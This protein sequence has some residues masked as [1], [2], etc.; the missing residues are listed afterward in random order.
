ML[1][2]GIARVGLNS[3]RG[4]ALDLNFLSGAF[5]GRI[6]FSRPSSATRINAAG[7]LEAVAAGTPR[8]DYDPVTLACKGLLVEEQ[9]TNYIRNSTMQGAAAGVLPTNWLATTSTN[10]ITRSVVGTGTED[11]IPYV[12]VRFAGTPTT[13]NQYVDVTF[14]GQN[15]TAASGQTWTLA[16]YLRLVGGSLA[17][18]TNPA[19]IGYAVPGFSDM[20]N[21]PISGLSGAP[22]RTQRISGSKTYSDATM[23]GISPRVG[24]TINAGA[25]VD[26]TVRIGLPQLEQG[27]FSTSPIPTTTA[28][29]TRA[30]DIATLALGSWFN[31]AEGTLVADVTERSGAALGAI[32]ELN[33]GSYINRISLVRPT[34][35]ALYAGLVVVG[36]SA[37][38]YGTVSGVSAGSHRIACAYKAGDAIGAVDGV[39]SPA[40]A[41]ASLPVV[42]ALR[43]GHESSGAALLNGHIRRIRYYRTRLSNTQLQ[44]LTA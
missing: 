25:T 11:G 10:G 20:I 44:A 34:A 21:T 2:L 24:F 4:A 31:A 3:R 26:L 8:I 23:T 36:G 19:L 41:P 17:G 1:G 22:L 33:D 37:L 12:D 14:D 18:V 42:S 15:I 5:D 27:A 38:T 6:T 35:S 43:L 39:L 9:R 30:A 32:A 40:G 7:L 29:A 16:A 28:Q 13:G